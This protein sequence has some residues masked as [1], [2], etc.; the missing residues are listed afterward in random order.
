[1]N[2]RKLALIALVATGSAAFAA[3]P[4]KKEEKPKPA[5][6]LTEQA[7]GV[8]Y[9]I[10]GEYLAKTPAV[11]L[12]IQVIAL[13]QDQYR[14]VFLPGGLPGAGWDRKTKVEG[15]AKADGQTL[16]FSGNG[17]TATL[18][19]G[20]LTGKLPTGETFTAS[21]IIRSSPTLGAKP[22]QGA[23]ILFDGK[24]A[25]AWNNGKV[26]EQGYLAAGATTKQSFQDFTLHVEFML[27]FMPDG[28]GQGRSNS[29]VYL[30]NRYEVQVLDSFG[31]KGVDNEC[32]GLY[33]TSAPALNMCLPPLQWQTYDIDF[34]AAKFDADGK[35]IA[36]AVL[37]VSHNG[38]IIQ[39]KIQLPDKTG[40]GQKEGPTPGPI[41]LQ[42]HGDPVLYRNIWL[43]PK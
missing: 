21:K 9:Q 35:K 39:N 42:N 14:A 10:Q 4:A 12:G 22:L 16:A 26:T 40:G 31:L 27:S 19:N 43:I 2:L 37:T 29:G 11:S 36:P 7:G 1:M 25:D 24:N 5:A 8:A 18:D 41:Q 30:Q 6:Y 33:R 3:E 32:G 34:T 23:V 13:G 17:Y 28:R 20:K 38:V 15:E